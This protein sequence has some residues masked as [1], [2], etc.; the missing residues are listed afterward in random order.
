GEAHEHLGGEL[1]NDVYWA[2]FL[3]RRF[4]AVLPA[5]RRDDRY[6]RAL[7]PTGGLLNAPRDGFSGVALEAIEGDDATLDL[8]L[9][10]GSSPRPIVVLSGSNTW[11]FARL[12]GPDHQDESRWRW[13][14]LRDAHSGG[15]GQ[16]VRAVS[17]RSAPF[18]GFCGGAQI[19]AL[20][21]AR[22]V[23]QR[24]QP[25]AWF[26][27]WDDA[28]IIDATL[29]RT[30]GRPIRGFAEAAAIFRSWPGDGRPREPVTF[31]PGDELFHD[32]AGVARRT[33]THAFPK[34]HADVVRPSAFLV[35]VPL[36]SFEVLATS[37]FCSPDVISA[38]PNDKAYTNPK[39]PGRC[40]QVPEVFRSAGGGFP[41]IGAQ[42]HAEQYDFSVAADSDPPESVADARLFLAAEY[43]SIVD[44]YLSSATL[45]AATRTDLS[46]P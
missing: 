34:S 8:P 31:I 42:F 44:A 24:S 46:A 10:E 35:G 33:V 13:D 7:G 12:S 14:P 15:M 45:A 20:L 40:I 28:A 6:A 25:R 3:Q 29:R 5:L 22:A 43:E 26:N 38:G 41:I 27:E 2:K 30:T 32:V 1:A 23:A 17:R 19:L 16:L 9:L 36:A 37:E 11:D 39:G 21:E 18:L 4:S